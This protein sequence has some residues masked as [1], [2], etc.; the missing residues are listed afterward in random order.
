MNFSI[1]TQFSTLLI[2]L[3][4]SACFY[5]VGCYLLR[6]LNKDIKHSFPLCITIGMSAYLFLGGILNS[7]SLADRTAL[8]VSLVIGVAASCAYIPRLILLI[9]DTKYRNLDYIALLP[10]FFHLS[11]TIFLIYYL[12]PPHGSFNLGDDITTY[13]ARPIRMLDSGSLSGNFFGLMP[14]DSLGGQAFLQG[15]LLLFF[16]IDYLITFDAIFCFFIGGLLILSISRLVNL[17]TLHTFLIIIFYTAANPL[18][19]NIS[20]VFSTLAFSLTVLY[21]LICI[22]SEKFKLSIKNSIIIGSLLASLATLKITSAVFAYILLALLITIYLIINTNKSH[23]IKNGLIITAI[24]ILF[25]SPWILI[26]IHNITATINSINTPN[27]NILMLNNTFTN[28]ISCLYNTNKIYY[29][30]TWSFATLLLISI[31]TS[32]YGAFKL[33]SFKYEPIDILLT[34]VGGAAFIT[35]LV[36]L[37]VFYCTDVFRYWSPIGIFATV[38]IFLLL[39][40][41]TP[42]HRSSTTAIYSYITYFILITS[43]SVFIPSSYERFNRY[44]SNKSYLPFYS[45]NNKN[46]STKIQGLL[47]STDNHDNLIKWQ[48]Q[49]NAEANILAIVDTPYLLDFKRNHI[50]FFTQPS[51]MTPW[52]KH[53]NYDTDS[54][55]NILSSNNIEYIILQMGGANPQL[56]QYHHAMNKKLRKKLL[57]KNMLIQNIARRSIDFINSV[58]LLSK[59]KEII[60][61]DNAVLIYK[62]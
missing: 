7:L 26:H 32:I 34:I 9:R 24:S 25:L 53:F 58:F 37:N 1:P 45:I 59:N 52:L 4:Y 3:L 27:S 6:F 20:P 18:Q 38:S 36:Y 35:F 2:I 28:N 19:V 33:F 17:N 54:V 39:A 56:N 50:H 16:P 62:L 61:Q 40:N 60:F 30:S 15:F 10:I 21:I 12:S 41:K 5:G 14:L 13:I 44:V 43:I 46:I 55:E 23:P 8:I 47:N 51:L 57:F 42:L 48:Q 11:F 22:K 49:A 29:V 31:T